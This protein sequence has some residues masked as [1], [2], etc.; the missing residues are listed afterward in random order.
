MPG[1][2]AVPRERLIQRKT[3]TP[4]IR[5]RVLIFIATIPALC[6]IFTGIRLPVISIIKLLRIPQPGIAVSIVA[7]A[8][9]GDRRAFAYISFKTLFCDFVST[10]ILQF[11][12]VHKALLFRIKGLESTNP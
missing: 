2:L 8:G 6:A 5:L 10:E 1:V 7:M 3:G 12:P 9:P 11:S 4:F